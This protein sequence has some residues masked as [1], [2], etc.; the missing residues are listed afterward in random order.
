ME[1]APAIKKTAALE[2]LWSVN[3]SDK[4]D[5]ALISDLDFEG[6]VV[7]IS[8]NNQ[9]TATLNYDQGINNIEMEVSCSNETVT[10]SM[11]NFLHALEKAKALLHKCFH[12]DQIHLIND[13]LLKEWGPIGTN[14]TSDT[15]DLYLEHAHEIYLII[16]NSNSPANLFNYLW[17]LENEYVKHG[18]TRK[19]TEEFSQML[20]HQIK[21]AF[22]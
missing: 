20:F 19:K 2:A 10:F 16:Q 17:K 13:L 22:A 21:K 4:F 1:E 11:E 3:M 12:E 5:I 7:E 18:D 14:A 15:E 8:F 9:L 6:M